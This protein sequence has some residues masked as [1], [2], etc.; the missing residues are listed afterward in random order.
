ML[1]DAIYEM[2]SDPP[3]LIPIRTLDIAYCLMS[4]LFLH[5]VLEIID[6]VGSVVPAGDRWKAF[7]R[8]GIHEGVPQMRAK[9][10]MLPF[11]HQGDVGIP[12]VHAQRLQDRQ[13]DHHVPKVID[14]ANEQSLRFSRHRAY[15]IVMAVVG[16]RVGGILRR[17]GIVTAKL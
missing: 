4:G 8:L 16:I 7:K 10:T 2:Q 3:W 5:R 11:H 12:V 14:P 6:I 1:P 17:N 15:L 9:R 13:R